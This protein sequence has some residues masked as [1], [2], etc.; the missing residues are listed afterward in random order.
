MGRVM[1]EAVRLCAPVPGLPLCAARDFDYKG[2]RIAAGSFI[3]IS[4]WFTHTSEHFWREPRRFDPER[5]SSDRAEDREHPFKWVPFG[6]GAPKCI[7][8]FFGEMEVKAILHQMLLRSEEHTS[9]LQSLMR[10]SY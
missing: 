9:E 10:T 4:P 7:G 3:S 5:F 1:K 2:F 6:G 8:L